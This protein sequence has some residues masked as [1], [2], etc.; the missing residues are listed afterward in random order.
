MERT[1]RE[2]ELAILVGALV[3]DEDT[4]WSLEASLDELAA[5]AESAGVIVVGRVTQRLKR[6]VAATFIGSGK[7]QEIGEAV[8]DLDADVV[9][10]DHE[11]SPRQQR[12]LER[13]WDVKVIDRTALILDVFAQHA[14]TREGMLQVELAQYEYRLPRLT[15]MWTHLAR[16]AGGRAGGASGG[17]GV[18]GPGEAQIEIDR[19]EIGR[20]IS[21]LEKQIEQLRTQR[22]QARRRRR[23]SGLLQI[24]LVGYTNAGK[25]TL[26]NRIVGSDVYTADQLFATLDPTTRRVELP[27]GRVAL[28][29]DTVGFIQ[30]LPTELV[31][32]FRATLEEVTEADLLLHIVDVT[33]PDAVLQAETVDRVLGELGVADLPVVVAANKIDAEGPIEE[34]L[35]ELRVWA[36]DL[37]PISAL[38]GSGIT[39]LLEAVDREMQSRLQAIEVLVPYD[40]GDVLNLLHTHGIVD[41]EQYV[42]GGTLVRA[43]VPLY[44]LGSVGQ[45]LTDTGQ[46]GP[47]G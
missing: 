43:R 2:P 30:R 17:V 14:R 35:R 12:N 13:A 15:R 22:R 46:E 10:F 33:H 16:Q 11:L 47:A 44:M 1:K 29:S 31:A 32:A 21:F 19:R 24:S 36:P 37:V 38:E 8:V 3:E 41:E 45:Y 23:R 39:E 4:P 28:L 34:H 9:L 25:S 6:P 7:V 42:E 18:R 5:L 26:L 27:S 20:R 40:S